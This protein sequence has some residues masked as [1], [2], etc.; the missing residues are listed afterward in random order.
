MMQPSSG[1]II[2]SDGSIVNLVTL[3]GGG[4]PVSDVQYD[5]DSYSPASGLILGED[6][7]AYDLAELLKNHG[8]DSE[9]VEFPVP[10]VFAITEDMVTVEVDETK[11]AAPYSSSYGYTGITIDSAKLGVKDWFEGM[12]VFF[13][14]N[15]KMLPASANR[16]VRVR[17]DDGAWIPCME[18]AGTISA[19][20]TYMA[21]A[22]NYLWVYSTKFQ[23]GG[24]L[25]HNSDSNTT[26]AYLVNTIATGI[27]VIDPK[28]Y[29]AR[30]GLAF[31]TTPL[32]DENGIVSD[33]RWSTLVASSSTGTTKKAVVP[34]GGKFY[35]DR[36]PQ[37]IYSANIAAGAKS[38]AATYQDYNGMDLRYSVNVSAAHLTALKKVFL[39]LKNFDPQDMSFESDAALGSIMTLDK[40]SERFPAS[41]DGD[42]YLYWLGWTGSTYYTLIPNFT[43]VNRIFKYTPSTGHFE[44][45]N[46]CAG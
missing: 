19:G 38:A 40:I 8:S 34:A 15:T 12:V 44:A 28:G 30:Y 3:L 17:I 13:I 27:T 11:G 32:S 6:G 9:P 7:R 36:H 5:P 22:V 20:N 41:E 42:I 14:S 26:Y 21:K 35:I 46:I 2:T 45:C 29:G 24:A 31:A 37:Y 25:H 4:T 18:P 43:S 10:R 39:W 1:N 16:N 23:A 33:E